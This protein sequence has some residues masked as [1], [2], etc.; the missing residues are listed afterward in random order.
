MLKTKCQMKISDFGKSITLRA[1]SSVD[2]L[3][4]VAVTT[5]NVSK[6]DQVLS[7]EVFKYFKLHILQINGLM[8]KR[9][10][11]RSI[12]MLLYLFCIKAI[13]I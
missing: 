1:R 12:T 6:D 8:Q 11:S 7:V 2:E 4:V 3:Q 5:F 9:L 10:N 13:K